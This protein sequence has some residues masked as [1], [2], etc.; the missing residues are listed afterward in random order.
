MGVSLEAATITCVVGRGLTKSGVRGR[1]MTIILAR[2][3]STA[4]R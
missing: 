4:H 3:V 1:A 2:E